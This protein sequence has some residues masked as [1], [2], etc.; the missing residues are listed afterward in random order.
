MLGCAT[1][2][3]A[4]DGWRAMPEGSSLRDGCDGFAVVDHE[5]ELRIAATLAELVGAEDLLG[6]SPRP[7]GEGWLVIV[8]GGRNAGRIYESDSRDQ[9]LERTGETS[10]V[11][12]IVEPDGLL[13]AENRCRMRGPIES[14]IVRVPSRTTVDGPWPICIRAMARDADG[15]IWLLADLHPHHDVEIHN[16]L[17]RLD[18]SGSVLHHEHTLAREPELEGTGGLTHMEIVD[19]MIWLSGV[20][21][22]VIRLRRDGGRWVEERIVP[23]EC[24]AR[25]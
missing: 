16:V 19:E 5:G 25:S 12:A 3:A 6:G 7:Q 22:P 1:V 15:R 14:S 17:F 20:E 11:A 4:P 24:R 23:S 18:A 8:P 2:P 9:P 13:L 21:T 10:A